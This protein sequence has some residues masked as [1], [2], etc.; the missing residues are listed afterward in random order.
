MCSGSILHAGGPTANHSTCPSPAM[1]HACARTS[2][3]RIAVGGPTPSQST[4]WWAHRHVEWLSVGPQ[5]AI[6]H[7]CGPTSA[8]RMAVGGSPDILHTL[9]LSRDIAW[10]SHGTT[11]L[12]LFSVLLGVIMGH[13]GSIDPGK[14]KPILLSNM[15]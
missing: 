2:A 1:L 5:P 4:C 9:H 10:W 6:L 12:I 14:R 11:P 13:P 8:C 3:C 15:I 7:A